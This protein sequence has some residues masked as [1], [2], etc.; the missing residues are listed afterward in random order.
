MR[1]EIVPVLKPVEIMSLRPTQMTVGMA[2][3]ERKRANWRKRMEKDGATFLGNHMIPCVLGPKEVMW[4]VDHHHLA[5]ALHLEDVKHVFVS[6]VADLTKID[7]ATFTT[8]MENRNWLHPYDAKGE[9]RDPDDLPKK[10]TKMIDDP[11]RSLAGEVREAGGYAKDTTPFSEFMWAD[12][13]RR[14]IELKSGKSIPEDVL[15]KALVLAHS[16]KANYLPG[17]CGSID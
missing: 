14:R 17:W 2:E 1:S 5:L 15:T 8:Y 10:I 6:V 16:P 12:Y 13:F 11:Y 7:K 4:V 9:R 3:V